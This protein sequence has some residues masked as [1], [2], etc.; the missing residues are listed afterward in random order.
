MKV[1]NFEED[2]GADFPIV[3]YRPFRSFS[4]Y[5]SSSVLIQAYVGFDTPTRS[6]VVSPPAA[7]IP[8]MRTV[9]LTGIKVAFDWRY[10]L[11]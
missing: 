9:V 11:K 8:P 4:R 7:P 3:E 10:Y 6:E 2:E 5:Q 1:N